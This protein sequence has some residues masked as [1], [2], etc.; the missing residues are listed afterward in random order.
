VLGNVRIPSPHAL[1]LNALTGG[2]Y[3]LLGNFLL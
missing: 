2:G 3:P 1:Q